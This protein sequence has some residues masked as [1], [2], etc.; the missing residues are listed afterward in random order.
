M[1]CDKDFDFSSYFANG[2]LTGLRRLRG[3]VR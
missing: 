3:P 1:L 2:L